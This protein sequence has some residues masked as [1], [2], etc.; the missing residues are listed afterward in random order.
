MIHETI[1]LKDVFK[2]LDTDATLT[3]YVRDNLN[4]VDINRKRAS[5]L[6]CPGGAYWRTAPHEGEPVA[7][8]FLAKGYNAFV[9][10]YSTRDRSE[11]LYPTQ[12]L[13]ASAAIAYIRKNCEKYNVKS[14]S[15]AICGF[16]AGGH[17]AAS[18]GMFW[19]EKFIEEKLGI[20]HGENKPNGMILSY[21]VI[22]S[23][24]FANQ[25]SFQMLLGEEAPQELRDKLSLENAVSENT[26]PAFIWATF[27]DTTVPAENSLLLA[28]AMKR[29]NIPFELH[30]YPTGRHGLSLGNFETTPED[31]PERIALHVESW[32]HLCADWIAK[33]IDK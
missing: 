18:V 11:R 19:S 22:S 16:S 7:L 4:E 26:P 13:E 9:L 30:I 24:E 29:A 20:T 6:V 14:D 3:C 23:G 27:D 31:D 5:V 32:L 33:Y 1:H 21:P 15:I 8:S 17:L 25:Y 10:D 28:S 12:L 2:G